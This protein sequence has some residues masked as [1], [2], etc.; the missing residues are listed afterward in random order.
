M[1]EDLLSVGRVARMAELSS[2]SIRRL[3]DAGKI[4]AL[5]V[6]GG[7]RFVERSAAE[8][9]VQQRTQRREQRAAQ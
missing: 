8:A 6:V 2:E 5:R 3:I 9:F 7:Q 1:A 4:P